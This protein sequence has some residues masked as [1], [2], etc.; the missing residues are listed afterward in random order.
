[1]WELEPR[2]ARQACGL[3]LQ[4]ECVIGACSA[5]ILDPET[6]RAAVQQLKGGAWGRVCCGVPG[7]QI[8]SDPAA[9]WLS[10]GCSLPRSHV[11]RLATQGHLHR[12]EC[13]IFIC[14]CHVVSIAVRQ[15]SPACAHASEIAWRLRRPALLL[16]RPAALRRQRFACSLPADGTRGGRCH[17]NLEHLP[18]AGGRNG[19]V[20]SEASAVER[21]IVAAR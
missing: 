12:C 7:D 5:L 20:R 13:V 4:L 16:L 1:M 3:W 14:K 18:P 15:H 9:Q 17:R 10:G 21:Y 19:R 8:P 2:C 6:G 11:H